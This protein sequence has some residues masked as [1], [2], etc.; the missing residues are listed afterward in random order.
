[1][2]RLLD[3]LYREYTRSRLAE[4]DAPDGFA[5]VWKHAHQ[6]RAEEVGGLIRTLS[7]TSP[8]SLPTESIPADASVPMLR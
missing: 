8:S 4:M 5:E 3:L 7:A 1:M 6:R 2:S